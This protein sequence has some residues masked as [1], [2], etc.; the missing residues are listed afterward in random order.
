MGGSGARGV[1]GSGNKVIDGFPGG[2]S[3]HGINAQGRSLF[4]RGNNSAGASGCR[5]QK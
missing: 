2:R 4:R 5:G 1:H 3:F